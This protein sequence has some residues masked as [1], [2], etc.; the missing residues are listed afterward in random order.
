MVI[1]IAFVLLWYASL[2]FQTF[3][4]HRYAAHGAFKMSKF[5]EKGFF[6]L[7]Y[8]TQGPSYLSPRAYAIMH[9]MHHAYTDT[10]KDPHSPAFSKNVF[11]MMWKTKVIYSDIFMEK[12]EIE[13]RFLK[14]LPDWRPFDKFAHSNFSRLIWA[15]IYIALFAHFTTSLW[16]WIFL[17]FAL[18]MGPLHGAVIN[19][20]AHKYGYDNFKMKN[21]AH[22]LFSV[23]ILMLGESYHNNHHQFP[24]SVNFGRRWHELDPVYPV[25][26]VL[27]WMRIIR[28]KKPIV[29]EKK[30]MDKQAV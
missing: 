11:D 2:F 6:I 13:E 1:L 16:Q 10:D 26:K 4:Q 8:I 29:I 21:T 15:G 28:L 14:N 27:S 5:W 7:T 3:F 23:D 19:W 25:I 12:V 20:Y 22:N 17:P 24:S 30:L 9:R 18:V